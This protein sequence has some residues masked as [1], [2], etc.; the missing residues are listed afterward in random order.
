M[1]RMDIISG[2][3]M[4]CSVCETL[5]ERDDE[6]NYVCPNPACGKGGLRSK[7]GV[8]I[9]ADEKGNVTIRNGKPS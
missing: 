9:V 5:L 8:S 3:Y 4:A 1:A 7:D 6:G 2:V